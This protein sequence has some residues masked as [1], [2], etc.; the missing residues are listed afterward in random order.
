MKISSILKLIT[1]WPQDWD[2]KVY[3]AIKNINKKY[4]KNR[5]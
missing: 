4:V 1:K 3:L 2:G 5:I